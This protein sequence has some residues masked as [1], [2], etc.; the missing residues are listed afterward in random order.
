M[1][2][3]ME[4]LH[5]GIQWP[6]CTH[7][8]DAP[9][10]CPSCLSRYKQRVIASAAATIERLEAKIKERDGWIQK[11]SDDATARARELC[12]EHSRA[13]KAE[14][15]WDEARALIK[16]WEYSGKQD[17]RVMEQLAEKIEELEAE[18]DE[19]L[20]DFETTFRQLEAA[21]KERD[22]NAAAA[23]DALGRAREH[24]LRELQPSEPVATLVKAYAARERE[25]Q[26]LREEVER[27]QVEEASWKEACRVRDVI[28]SE[29]R[30]RLDAALAALDDQKFYT[31]RAKTA[32]LAAAEEEVRKDGN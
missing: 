21:I 3:V 2:D 31:A 15:E 30:S 12:E 4:R 7:R 28:L 8:W 17:L 13:E 22:A 9:E 16:E 14:R 10:T 29:Q 26:A 32:G 5:D 25:A 27:L 20:H 24:L 19:A 23:G 18:R 11:Q 1:S 6:K